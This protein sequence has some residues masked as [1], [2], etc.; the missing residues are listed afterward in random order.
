MSQ[1]LDPK[2]F[3]D[4]S[5]IGLG[6]S[7]GVSLVVF[8]LGGVFLDRWLGTTPWLTL[9]G[10]ALGLIAAGYLLY[11]LTLINRPDRR[12]GPIARTLE[13]RSSRRRRDTS[14]DNRVQ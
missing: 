12:A 3:K 13:G 11:E 2:D 8:I 1:G 9:I 4:Y 14:S 5:A 6:W 10:V 7:I